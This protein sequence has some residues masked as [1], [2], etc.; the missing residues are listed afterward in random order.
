MP[1]ISAEH[2]VASARALWA[3]RPRHRATC[4]YAQATAGVVPVVN[5]FAS[6]SKRLRQTRNSVHRN[7]TPK[8]LRAVTQCAEDPTL[9]QSTTSHA[10]WCSSRLRESFPWPLLREG[11]PSRKVFGRFVVNHLQGL[12]E[13]ASGILGQQLGRNPPAEEVGPKKFCKRRLLLWDATGHANRGSKASVGVVA[14]A[15]NLLRQVAARMPASLRIVG[16]DPLSIVHHDPKLSLG[17]SRQIG[18]DCYLNH[19]DILF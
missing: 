1:V 19:G 7:L 2:L 4:R 10:T 13:G 8:S 15:G 16:M 14:E 9:L 18:Q 12:G 6:G 3:D 17:E 5:P 11:S